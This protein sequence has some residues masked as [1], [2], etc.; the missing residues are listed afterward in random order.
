MKRFSGH[1]EPWGQFVDVKVNAP[2]LLRIEITKKKRNRV[3]V[4][5]VCDPYQP[6]EAKYQLTR[7]CLEIL[8]LNEWPVT[9]QTRSPLVLRDMD[10][11]TQ[12]KEFEVGFSITTSDDV[13]RQL[14]EPNAP[15]I[16]ERVDALNELHRAGLKTFVMIAPILPGAEDLAPLLADKVDCVILDRMNYHYADWIYRKF[17]LQEKLTDEYFSSAEQKLSRTFAKLGIDC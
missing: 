2:E 9:I 7:Q 4:S 10:I 1:S 6:L 15:P 11:L 3:W 14:F 12:G 13:I 5:G 16:K 17:G 8:A